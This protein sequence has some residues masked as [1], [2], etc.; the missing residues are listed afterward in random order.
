MSVILENPSFNVEKLVVAGNRGPCMGV[1]RS[2]RT[3]EIVFDMVDGREPIYL[4]HPL[5]HNDRVTAYFTSKGAIDV[6]NDLEKV[7]EDGIAFLSAHGSGPDIYEVAQ[8]RNLLTVDTT[9]QLVTRVIDA[10]IR[11]QKD[12][13]F[14]PYIGVEG[15]PER[16]AVMG[17][18]KSDMAQAIQTIEDVDLLNVPDEVLMTVL[19]QTTLSLKETREIIEH[20]KARY[21]DRLENPKSTLCYATTNRQESLSGVLHEGMDMALVI[22]SKKSHNTSQLRL[23]GTEAAVPTRQIN[24]VD[25]IQHDWFT[26]DVRRVG[27]TSGASVPEDFTREV[28]GY[29]EDRGVD[30]EIKQ[31]VRPEHPG[32]FPLPVEDIARIQERYPTRRDGTV[33]EIPDIRNAQIRLYA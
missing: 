12:G 25:D 8:A 2:V 4:N 33:V 27:L 3:G 15:H 5:V 31:P 28:I 21:G 32:A 16:N 26:P 1:N 10:G 19:T 6:Q 18:L 9:C 23:L 22:G 7:P 20:L 13:K 11:A 30:I 14:V 24:G 29:F 17:Y